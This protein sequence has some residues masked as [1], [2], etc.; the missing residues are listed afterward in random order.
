MD[1][2]GVWRVLWVY[3]HDYGYYNVAANREILVKI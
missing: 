1:I 2:W 3:V